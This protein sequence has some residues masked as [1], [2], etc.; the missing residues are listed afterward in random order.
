MR[1]LLSAEK[2]YCIIRLEFPEAV[3]MVSHFKTYL[4]GAEFSINK[5]YTYD[6]RR[7]KDNVLTQFKFPID[8]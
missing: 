2:N 1:V 8:H 5:D 6:T 4:Y 7:Q 3:N